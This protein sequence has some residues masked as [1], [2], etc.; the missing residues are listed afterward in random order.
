MEALFLSRLAINAV[1]A[2]AAAKTARPEL[3]EAMNYSTRDLSNDDSPAH[4]SLVRFLA[5]DH[6]RLDEL[7]RRAVDQEGPIDQRAYDGFR[8]SLLRHIGMEEK[9][10]L[11]AAQRFGG[12]P[13][14]IAHTLRLDHGALACLLMPT[15]TPAIIIALRAILTRH[16]RLEEGPDG[17]YV[18]CE[19]LA[20]P[21][22]GTLLEHLKAAPEVHVMPHSDSR[23]VLET[24]R[25]AVAR[26]GYPLPE[27]RAGKEPDG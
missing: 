20:G 7:F 4:R 25:R 5:E 15:P 18:H 24:V 8:A 16:N 22:A 23:Q 12:A 11:P 9:I 14:P 27:D 10:L 1:W 21:E 6:A 19:R 13:L 26:A 17:L 2:R 3:I